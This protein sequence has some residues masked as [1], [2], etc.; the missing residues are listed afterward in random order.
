MPPG[1]K[2]VLVTKAVSCKVRF[3]PGASTRGKD[4]ALNGGSGRGETPIASP[5]GPSWA[6]FST[7]N[8]GDVMLPWLNLIIASRTWEQRAI[9]GGAEGETK[10]CVI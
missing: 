1:Q 6:F 8:L 10:G 2:W 5:F 4:T 9:L 7:V 3:R